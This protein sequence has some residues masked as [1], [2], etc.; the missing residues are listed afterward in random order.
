MS[1]EHGGIAI[2]NGWIPL[3]EEIL[4]FCQFHHDNNGYPQL[5]A[6]QIK[7]KFGTLRFYYH[8]EE[9]DSDQAENGKK[10][11][12][13]EEML[14]GAISFAENQSCHI[15]ESCGKAGTMTSGGWRAVRCE[16]CT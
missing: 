15:C 14:E 5:V 1:D 11:N 10:F 9:C 7:E 6:D 2:G 13:S 4:K 12:R 3:I 16:E 8:F